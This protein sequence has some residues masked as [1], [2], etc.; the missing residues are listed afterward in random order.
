[1][2]FTITW[3]ESFEATPNDENYGYDLDTFIQNTKIGVRERA[4]IEH[5]WK[6]GETDGQHVPGLVRV[7]KVDTEANILAFSGKKDAI[8]FSSDTKKLFRNT[9]DGV[10][11][12]VIDIDHGS[13]SGL[14]DDDHVIYLLADGTRA[15]SGNLNLNSNKVTDLGAPINDND[16]ATKKYVDDQ[17]I[18]LGP[19]LYGDFENS[20][21]TISGNDSYNDIFTVDVVINY[22]T[23][24]LF[25]N[26]YLSVTTNNNAYT[27]TLQLYD[28]TT[29][30]E[31]VIGTCTDAAEG[32]MIN[33]SCHITNLTVGTHS[34]KLRAKKTGG[35][36]TMYDRSITILKAS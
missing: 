9:A 27:I 23:D 2:S 20:G 5:I 25:L 31:L 28:S 33:I 34:I 16:G 36:A 7:L 24:I 10:N 19:T 1:M 22:V 3:N 21:S 32:S 13:L 29:S 17:F 18:G 11:W 15:L 12:T 35:T 14:T 30:T 6:I 4:E 8:A 26:G